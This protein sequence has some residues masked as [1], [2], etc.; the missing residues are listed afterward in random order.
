MKKLTSL[1]ILVLCA[2]SPVVAQHLSITE[3][4]FLN[5]GNNFPED[6]LSGKTVVFA[7]ADL[8]KRDD[9]TV[10]T[11]QQLV[12]DAHPELKSIGLDVYSYYNLQDVTAGEGMQQ[13]MAKVFNDNNVKNII[14]ISDV[15]DNT[16]KGDEIFVLM[17]TSFNGKADYVSHN[18]EAYITKGKSLSGVL[19]DLA[20]GAKKLSGGG[21][22][23][24]EPVMSKELYFIKGKRI[25]GFPDLSGKTLYVHEFSGIEVPDKKPGGVANDLIEMK[26]NRH[27]VDIKSKNNLM[28]REFSDYQAIT[29]K[30]VSPA[31]VPDGAQ[32]VLT[33]TQSHSEGVQE[34]LGYDV[35]EEINVYKVRDGSVKM[36]TMYSTD[37][38]YKFYIKD[39]KTGDIYLG[40]TI[41][42]DHNWQEALRNY[43][44]NMKNAKK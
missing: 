43:L 20:K 44:F 15:Y 6:L 25:E 26:V 1:F 11:W 41:D 42:C 17:V 18:Q 7:H 5:Y 22:M 39:L 34:M 16:G 13:H 24:A 2:L 36:S 33:Y 4:R 9:K 21:S 40:E 28:R 31:E 38:V 27:N 29:R 12:E 32:Y 3:A 35:E 19:K 23:G 30:F 8:I 10:Q 37:H 14:M